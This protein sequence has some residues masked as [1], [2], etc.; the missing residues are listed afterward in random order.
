MCQPG[1]FLYR[2]IPLISFLPL[3]PLGI[4]YLVAALA[5]LGFSEQCG[6]SPRKRREFNY[7]NEASGGRQEVNR[8]RTTTPM[9][10][11]AKTSTTQ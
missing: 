2:F 6:S 1:T 10:P 5:V 3:S 4:D 7:P 11:Q 9:I 8:R